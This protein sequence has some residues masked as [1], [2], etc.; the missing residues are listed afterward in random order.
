MRRRGLLVAAIVASC[1]AG[2]AG[3]EELRFRAARQRAHTVFHGSADLTWQG[4]T[5]FAPP[6]GSHQIPLAIAG[7]RQAA[8]G[9]G[10]EL[11]LPFRADAGY[12]VLVRLVQFENSRTDPPSLA[13]SLGDGTPT[14]VA[15]T[16]GGGLPIDKIEVGTQARYE[17]RLEGRARCGRNELRVRAVSGSVMALSR[18]EVELLPRLPAGIAN[19]AA[20]LSLALWLLL[21]A[22]G[23]AR[24]WPAEASARRR[25]W[26]LAAGRAAIVVFATALALL[27]A[28]AAVRGLAPRSVKLRHLLYSHQD[29]VT[30]AARQDFLAELATHRC[31]A[32][33]CQPGDDGFRVDQHGFHT[34]PYEVA[35]GIGTYRLLGIGDSFMFGGGSVPYAEQLLPALERLLRAEDPRR[36]WELINL[37][38]S[39]I[40]VPTETALLRREGLRLDP[41]A[42]VWT[43]YLGNDITDEHPGIPTVAAS[44]PAL[45]AA[46]HAPALLRHSL[47]WRLGS[48]LWQLARAE[49]K[50]LVPACS[51]APEA[52]ASS[53]GCGVLDPAAAPP[54]YDPSG[55]TLSDES[56]RGYA[57]DRINTMYRRDGRQRIEPAVELLL[58]RMAAARPVLAG[59]RVLIVVIPD[60]LAVSSRELGRV[61][62]WSTELATVPFDLD[63]P[64]DSVVSGLRSLGY[65]VLDLTPAIRAALQRGELLYQPNDGHFGA[66]GNRLAAAQVLAAMRERGWLQPRQRAE[67]P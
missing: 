16:P 43:L 54:T 22:A 39:C 51:A 67:A 55:K 53:G 32:A 34:H 38:M 57:Q 6:A 19:G 4:R 64:H 15:T 29:P 1:L 59:R 30:A 11:R 3:W 40:G 65:P 18:V 41:D 12:P 48:H 24:R 10:S 49:P 44:A 13:L 21:A 66:G 36:A 52:P 27:L 14:E 5:Q 9:V 58:R 56:Y 2:G 7:S 31:A 50:L 8:P 46:S 45:P 61:L 47:L 42:V 28:E 60:E 63:F 17:A 35:K 33:P 25:F 37:G 20:A 23:L 26:R 62:A